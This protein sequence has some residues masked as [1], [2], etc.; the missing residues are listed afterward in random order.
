MH[1]M[2]DACV[3]GVMLSLWWHRTKV[4]EP[5]RMYHQK[6]AVTEVVV[7]GVKVIVSCCLWYLYSKQHLLQ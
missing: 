5:A 4:V 1:R 3:D 6:V 2:E 7:V